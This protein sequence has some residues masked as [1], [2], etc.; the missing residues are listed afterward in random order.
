MGKQVMRMGGNSELRVTLVFMITA[1]FLSAF[2]N[3]VGV[4]ALL[5]PVVLD[6]C[7]RTN[8]SPSRILIPLAFSSLMG[9]MTT[10]I[11]TPSN[12]LVNDILS[13]FGYRSFNIFAFVPVGGA[14]LLGG[15]IYLSTD[16]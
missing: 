5:L 16:R 4:T 1:A 7:R 13:D 6:I 2:M 8:W 10:L 12:I 3:N 15:L 11:G 9:G 14:I